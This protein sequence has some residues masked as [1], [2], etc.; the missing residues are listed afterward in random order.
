MLVSLSVLSVFV[1][2]F[3]CIH[4]LVR[5]PLRTRANP[6]LQDITLRLTLSLATSCT[7]KATHAALI[8]WLSTRQEAWFGRG[9]RL[10]ARAQLE[11]MLM[12]CLYASLVIYGDYGRLSACLIRFFNGNFHSLANSRK[13]LVTVTEIESATAPYLITYTLLSVSYFFPFPS[14][15]FPSPSP[16]FPSFFISVNFSFSP[17]ISP[18]S[19][20]PSSSHYQF[21]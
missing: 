9:S 10:R 14:Y 6:I 4:M 17:A 12:L 3:I 18:L 19:P 1:I 13:L 16:A 5:I 15:F 2:R 8:S 7:E 21:Y 11:F 20:S